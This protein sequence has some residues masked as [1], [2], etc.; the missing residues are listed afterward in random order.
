MVQYLVLF[1]SYKGKIGMLLA[2]KKKGGKSV[3]HTL[4]KT[5]L[6][7]SGLEFAT[8]Y[9]SGFSFLSTILRPLLLALITQ[10]LSGLCS[11]VSGILTL[12]KVSS[13]CPN[14]YFFNSSLK[15]HMP[16]AF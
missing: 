11:E 12:T 3:Y 14:I 9:M 2:M 7:P 10:Y 8:Q 4:L 15:V 6:S 13:Y 1:L 5:I 16:G